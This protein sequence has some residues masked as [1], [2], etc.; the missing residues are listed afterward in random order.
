MNFEALKSRRGSKY[1]DGEVKFLGNK[2]R[3]KCS[4]KYGPQN[5]RHRFSDVARKIAICLGL[6]VW[7]K[8]LNICSPFE[9]ISLRDVLVVLYSALQVCMLRHVCRIIELCVLLYECPV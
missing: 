8:Y 2:A 6:V 4:G 9:R 3:K 7:I 1:D 5:M